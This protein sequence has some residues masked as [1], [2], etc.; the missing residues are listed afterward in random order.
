M[1]TIP[2]PT[3]SGLRHDVILVADDDP[4]TRLLIAASLRKSGFRVLV[5]EDGAQA[6]EI[7]RSD[8][9]DLILLD[10]EMPHL[11]GFEVCTQVRQSD[12]SLQRQVPVVMV[13]GMDD[14]DSVRR[15]YDAGATDFIAKPINVVTLTHRIRY[16]LRA[17]RSAESL[18]IAEAC[19]S[20]M[21]SAIPDIVLRLTSDGVVVNSHRGMGRG[22][23][24]GRVP[25]GHTVPILE[26]D[27]LTG[28]RLSQVLPRELGSAIMG[29]IRHC[30]ASG[31]VC[32]GEFELSTEGSARHYEARFAR[33][34]PNDVLAVIRDIS[35]RKDSEEHIRSLAYH[36]TLTGM[37]NRQAF[38]DTLA[39]ELRQ[40]ARDAEPVAIL[41]L[42]LDGFKRINDSLGHLVGDHLLQSVADRLR[43]STRTHDSSGQI[44]AEPHLARLGG[45]EFTVLLRDIRGAEEAVAVAQRIKDA[46]RRPFVIDSHE[47][48][49][50]ASIGISQFPPDGDDAAVLL[51]CADTAMYHAKELGKNNIQLYAAS[52]TTRITHRVSLENALRKALERNE[53]VLVFQPQVHYPDGR[54]VGME[55]L[56]R[57]HHPERGIVSPL[58]FI[59][60]AEES[61][62]IVPIGEWVLRTACLQASAWRRAGF[63][64][65]RMAVNLS[66]AQFREATLLQ[67]VLGILDSCELPASALDIELTESSLMDDAECTVGTLQEINAS[68]IHLTIDDFGTGYSSM[69]YLKRFPVGA[70]KI[71]RSFI[72]DLPDDVEDAAITRAIIA[73]SMS[74]GMHVV[75]EGIETAEQARILSEYGCKLF[76]GYFFWKPMSAT[77]ATELLRVR[78]IR[79]AGH[80]LELS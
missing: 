33:I 6:I 4:T 32:S 28:R 41:F 43:H 9:P 38:L 75:A 13:T 31:Q 17:S 70:L 56:I 64:G 16:I 72:R 10:V 55:A 2:L 29:L 24:R 73:M 36:D 63:T 74:L 19:H 79:S 52:L 30:L 14:L 77:Q 8:L 22:D 62:L 60:I 76:Q 47:V 71:D 53:F 68:G 1:K 25:L 44:T 49:V 69:N 58:D 18:R 7:Y 15:A 23:E 48:T 27:R 80:T 54:I 59:P 5:A 57:W 11:D 45:D 61:G 39:Q 46:L 50:T 65:I 35:Q 40:R 66:A 37:L 78:A 51:K 67:T 26:S 3:Q 12:P 21:L 34:G 42:D 20:A